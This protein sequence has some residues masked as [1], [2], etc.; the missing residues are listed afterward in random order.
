MDYGSK[1]IVLTN[2]LMQVLPRAIKFHLKSENLV[3]LLALAST[4]YR[5]LSAI[6]HLKIFSTVH[7]K[8]L[9]EHVRE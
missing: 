8:I 1:E 7:F 5:A 6:G 9:S 4:C 2:K 3:Y